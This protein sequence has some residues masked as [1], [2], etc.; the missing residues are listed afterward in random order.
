MKT[1]RARPLAALAVALVPVLA[2]AACGGPTDF[3]AITDQL[4]AA[5]ND[6]AGGRA[7]TI[8]GSTATPCPSIFDIPP[9]DSGVCRLRA[10]DSTSATITVTL[11]AASEA[12]KTRIIYLCD[13]TH[14]KTTLTWRRY[15][16]SNWE[17]S[18]TNYDNNPQ[19]SSGKALQ[20]RFDPNNY[21]PYLYNYTVVA[22]RNRDIQIRVPSCQEAYGWLC[23]FYSD[24]SILVTTWD[25]DSSNVTPTIPQP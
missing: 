3:T 25:Y 22:A 10:G 13:Y 16:N 4:G 14:L 19:C 15:S 8:V 20:L 12:W 9:G 6:S 11:Q 18:S 5:A 23:P 7:G 24:P 2:L 21:Y 17:T 1:H